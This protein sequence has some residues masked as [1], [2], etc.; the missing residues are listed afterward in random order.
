MEPK[1]MKAIFCTK[2]GPPEVLKLGEANKPIPKDNEMLVEVRATAVTRSDLFIRGSKIPLYFKVLMRLYMGLLKPRKPIIG[3]VFAGIVRSIGSRITR[4][5]PGDEV[6]GM[7][8]F[9]LGAY[10]QFVCVKETDSTGGC[11]SLKPK[12]CT[13]EEATWAVYGGSL[14]HQFME[15]GN[16]K[17]GQNILIYGASGT[18]GTFAVQYGKTLGSTV[19]GVCS[20]QH[21]DFVKSLG[22]DHIL[23]YT[24]TDTLD[25]NTKFDFMLDAVGNAKTSKLK[26]A[27][28]KALGKEGIYATIDSKALQLSSKRLDLIAKLVEE[29]SIKPV[30]DKIYPLEKI[31]QAHRYVELGHKRGG[32][33]ITVEQ[34]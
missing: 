16:I 11:V 13:F 6:Y 29:G 3:L 14:A 15:T 2:Y 8:G 34:I 9:S 21:I 28:K 4:F 5:K 22:A 30:L 25:G 33:A 18:T 27:C 12:N 26:V 19:T 32:V 7:T 31:V 17:K 10:A 23:D 1:K 20:S 24:K